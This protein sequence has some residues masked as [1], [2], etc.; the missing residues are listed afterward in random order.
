MKDGRRMGDKEILK[1]SCARV[2][3]KNSTKEGK[4]GMIQGVR[5][6]LA[7]MVTHGDSP[8]S[9]KLRMGRTEDRQQSQT[10]KGT[11][12]LGKNRTG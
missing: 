1:D 6:T 7:K 3:L 4:V 10:T 9:H 2:R 8:I 12:R 5:A 11:V